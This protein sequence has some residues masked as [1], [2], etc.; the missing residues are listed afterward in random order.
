MTKA[1]SVT[2]GT[3]EVS[4]TKGTK[5]VSETKGTKEVSVTK[6]TKE[7]SETKGTKGVSV[8]KGTKEVSVTRGTKD[9]VGT[10]TRL[11]TKDIRHRW[12][13]DVRRETK[14]PL[15]I[16]GQMSWRPIKKVGEPK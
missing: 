15:L 10:T 6:G 13:K 16:G 11:G 12:N 2:K 7:V 8:T 14:Q 4:E 1:V 5:E 3:K 9:N